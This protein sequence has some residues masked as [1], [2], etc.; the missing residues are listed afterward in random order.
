M[1]KLISDIAELGQLIRLTIEILSPE[2]KITSFSVPYDLCII[3]T[4]PALPFFQ[5]PDSG[6]VK[7]DVDHVSDKGNY[8]HSYDVIVD[9]REE[10]VSVFSLDKIGKRSVYNPDFSGRDVLVGLM[11]DK[12]GTLVKTV[13]KLGPNPN[14]LISNVPLTFDNR[15]SSPYKAD[16]YDGFND[17]C[18]GY[19][20]VLLPQEKIRGLG[21]NVIISCRSFSCSDISLEKMQVEGHSISAR[22]CYF[23]ACSFIGNLR[24]FSS[25]CGGFSTD[26][27]RGVVSKHTLFGSESGIV[28]RNSSVDLVDLRAYF[29]KSALKTSLASVSVS[30]SLFV[31]CV[32][33]MKF[34]RMTRVSCK[35]T[36]IYNCKVGV[37]MKNSNYVHQGRELRVIGSELPVWMSAS[38][39]Y[40]NFMDFACKYGI[41]I[42]EY[43]FND[44]KYAMIVRTHKYGSIFTH[45]NTSSLSSEE[46]PGLETPLSISTMK[47]VGIM[48]EESTSVEGSC[49]TLEKSSKFSGSFRIN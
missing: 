23:S 28:L 11:V 48:P 18:G 9:K 2:I 4:K 34:T 15:S 29:V 35:E 14:E 22:G 39:L 17:N 32:S 19:G 13:F 30:Y 49:K 42:D 27:C 1:D 16:S 25:N 7:D 33:A 31:G 40:C 43:L 46:I 5:S 12:T 41:V 8:C 24:D 37:M 44:K 47:I 21:E 36:D 3:G 6:K 26:S 20:F 38:T 45:P 10:K